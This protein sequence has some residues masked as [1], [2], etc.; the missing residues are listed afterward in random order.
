MSGTGD[1]T[2][3]LRLGVGSKS[4]QGGSGDEVAL[5][6]EGI[7]DGGMH[8]EKALGG[9]R[10][11]E[12]LHFALASS[13]CLMQ[14]FGAIISSQALLMRA[15]QSQT[16][17]CRS[18]GAQLVGDQTAK[19]VPIGAQAVSHHV[20]VTPVILGTGHGEA[21]AEPIELFSVVSG[22]RAGCPTPGPGA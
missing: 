4:S 19:G 7:V 2:F 17:E 14:I 18:V 22:R 5:E 10:R 3:P 16:P 20:S 12:P 1:S 8:V 13:H 11:L 21:V 15:A 9:S 6:V